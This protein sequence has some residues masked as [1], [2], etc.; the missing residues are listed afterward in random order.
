MVIESVSTVA[1]AAIAPAM[2]SL[3]TSRLCTRASIRP[4]RNC[5][6]YMTPIS[7]A[8]SPVR[9][10]KTMRRVRLE[11]LCATKKLQAER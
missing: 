9:L 2:I 6:R 11:K 3:C 1:D 5:E 7:S 8:T 10:R 4:A